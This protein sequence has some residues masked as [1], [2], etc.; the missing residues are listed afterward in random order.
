MTVT[1]IYN[2]AHNFN[3]IKNLH[4]YMFFFLIN[5][6]FTATNRVT[7]IVRTNAELKTTE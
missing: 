7:R 3:D 5:N 6:S 1:F 4:K 2:I